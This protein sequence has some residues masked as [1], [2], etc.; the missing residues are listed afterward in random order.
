MGYIPGLNHRI[1]QAVQI[2][3]QVVDLRSLGHLQ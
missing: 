2:D 3:E 1:A